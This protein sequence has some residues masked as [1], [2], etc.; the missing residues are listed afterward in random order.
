MDAMQQQ[1]MASA[2]AGQV[3]AHLNRVELAL[4]AIAAAEFGFCRQ[5]DEPI[6]FARLKARPDSPLCIACQQANES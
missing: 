3:K 4:T 1:Q 5:C 2:N 6:A